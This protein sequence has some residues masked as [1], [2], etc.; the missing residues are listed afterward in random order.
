[1]KK[2]KILGHEY[3]VK[4]ST[5]LSDINGTPAQINFSKLVIRIDTTYKKSRQEEHLIHEIFEALNYHLE[6]ELP[7][8]TI[9]SLSEGLYG[10][11]KDNKMLKKAGV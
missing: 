4:Y 3:E 1:M 10:V 5:E 9:T 2:I 6:L 11:L 7:H 8:K